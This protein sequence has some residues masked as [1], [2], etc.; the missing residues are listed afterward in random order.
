MS[1]NKNYKDIVNKRKDTILKKRNVKMAKKQAILE[2]LENDIEYL[3][4]GKCV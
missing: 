3:N 1:N 2:K 4:K